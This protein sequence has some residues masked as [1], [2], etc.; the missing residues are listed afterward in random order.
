MFSIALIAEESEIIEK[1][2]TDL[3]DKG[4]SC[5]F[6]S[7]SDNTIDRIGTSAPHLVLAIVDKVGED[8]DI[9]NLLHRIKKELHLPVIA[10]I[11]RDVLHRVGS[12]EY[13]DD[14]VIE[15]WDVEEVALRSL[16][17]LK[18]INNIDSAGLI[19]CGDLIIDIARCEVFLDGRPVMLTYKEYELLHFLASNRG[20]VFSREALLN[21]VW[22]YDYYGGDRTVDVHIR[23]L[24]SKIEDATHTFIETVRNI[25]YR[26]RSED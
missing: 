17:T 8:I 25:G 24:R 16:L 7:A 15:P 12:S 22:G 20:H 26:F 14:F 3:V 5:L 2:S 23:R 4:F 18:R 19:K 13:I 9:W 6:V 21:K 1:L 10:L 11:S